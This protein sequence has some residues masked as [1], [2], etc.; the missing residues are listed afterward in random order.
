M[1]MYRL[2]PLLALMVVAAPCWPAPSAP[3]ATTFPL[4]VYWPWERVQ[5]LAD[6]A[7]LDKWTY[8]ERCL[9]DMRAHNVDSVW[10]VN[11][12]I[13]D[14]PRLADRMTARD[15][16]LVPALSELHY[17]VSW[18]RNNW[19]YLEQY[20]RRAV[21]AGAE[22]PAILAWCLCDEP[23]RSIVGE[24]EKY[25]QRFVSWGAKQPVVVVTMWGDSPTY[26]DKTDFAA[27][28]TDVYPFFAPG[29]PNGPNTPPTSRAWY[30]QH[31]T[32][33]ANV[34]YANG[35]T[36][37]VMPQAY[38]EVWG[39]WRYDNKGDVV[40]LPGGILHWRPPTPAEMRWQVWTA[41]AA[42]VRGFFWF[43]YAPEPEDHAKQKPYVGSIFPR[44]LAVKQETPLG[45]PGALTRPDG[46]A[47]LQYEALAQTFGA[48]KPLLPLLTGAVPAEAALGQV[49]PPGLLGTLLNVEAGR[50]FAV[51]V[52]DDPDQAHD[53]KVRLKGD[54]DLRDLIHGKVLPRAADGTATVTLAPGDGTLVE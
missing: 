35:K 30:R 11:L 15:M 24:M 41:L 47:S 45:F 7:N 18:R 1:Y 38:H 27:V 32:I 10:A 25:R 6:R 48:L 26:A 22:S 54:G 52:N 28:C 31:C 50:R 17:N 37:W 4:G 36:P 3:L 40:I 42:G 44:S 12:G 51:V 34:A 9:D 53:F 2:V 13:D 20:S 33:A 21:R 43:C 19:T 16:H 39:P 23:P 46:S 5:A 29:N 8:V 14:L 49:E